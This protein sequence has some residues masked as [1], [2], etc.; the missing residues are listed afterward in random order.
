[1][2]QASR[3]P[4][5][6]AYDVALLDLDGVVYVGT[7]PVPHAADALEEAR[8]DGLRLAFVTN[9]ASR[10][11]E[12]VARRITATGVSAAAEEVVTSAQAAAGILRE[13]WGVGARVAVLGA[14]GLIAACRD[15]GL[16]PV[17]VDDVA[18]A[19]V[20]GFGP[21]VV[22]SDVMRA[23]V[24]IREGLPWVASNTDG[25]FP[26]SYGLAP[27][28]GVLVRTI[29]DFS[30]VRPTV[31]GKPSRPLF[32]EAI[33][34]TGARRPLMVGDRLDTDIEGARVA[35]M[36]SLL[37]L[38]GVTGLAELL[39][40]PP[41]HRPDYLAPDLRGLLTRHQRP[42]REGESWRLGGWSARSDVPGLDVAGE[43]DAADWWRLVA[44][45]GWAATDAGVE[46]DVTA[47]T[48]PDPGGERAGRDTA[49]GQSRDGTKPDG[50]G[51][52]AA[53]AG[54]DPASE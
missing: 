12:E 9:N 44:S 43:G 50:P 27:G 29:S 17:G 6:T 32:D 49:P 8:K 28:H 14:E 15:A 20:S 11:P 22:W 30:G 5:W 23:A 35:G 19:I 16:E 37:V 42:T 7:D 45:A 48:A 47:L 4:L 46:I 18:S 52:D 33:A 26:T 21:E 1:M 53:R 3:G 2:L 31:A 10:T 54:R 25:T 34:R 41:E 38:T 39:G 51:D 24:H 36:P 40:A 13:R